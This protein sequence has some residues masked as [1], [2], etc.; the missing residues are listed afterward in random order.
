MTLMPCKP[1]TRKLLVLFMLLVFSLFVFQSRLQPTAASD[2]Q[3]LRDARTSEAKPTRSGAQPRSS[4]V[5][6]YPKNQ[7]ISRIPPVK[8]KVEKKQNNAAKILSNLARAGPLFPAAFSMS[9]FSVQGIVKGRWPLVVVYELEADSTAE[10]T[11]NTT[12][13]GKLESFRIPLR[14]TKGEPLEEKRQLP[15]GFGQKPQLGEI[16]FR[17]F[18]NG[19]EPNR[20]AHFFLYGLGVGDKAVGSVVVDQLKF[21]PPKIQPKLKEKASYSFHSLSDFDY[22]SADFMRVTYPDNVY[23][24]ET[25][26]RKKLNDGIGHD[27]W[28][29]KDWD[30]KNDKGKISPGRYQFRVRV[31]RAL[32][33]GGDWVSAFSQQVVKVE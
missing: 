22:G 17:A 10:V 25:V 6:T 5:V 31:W 9:D 20:P 15:E 12:N 27:E 14:P 11:I 32:Q 21:Q 26:A 3:S 16:S 18:K 33:S 13:N 24:F 29:M 4:L 19:P 23:H 1:L 2:E 30:G 28:L 8:I 7:K